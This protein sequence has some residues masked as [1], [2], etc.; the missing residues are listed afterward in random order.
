MRFLRPL[1]SLLLP[2]LFAHIIGCAVAGGPA[3]T[4]LT[5]PPAGKCVIYIYRK[6]HFTL[7]QGAGARYLVMASD[8]LVTTLDIGGYYRLEVTPGA[9]HF[10]IG[11]SNVNG[12]LAAQ[13]K[14]SQNY[15]DENPVAID[16]K[17]GETYYITLVSALEQVTEEQ[18][19]KDLDGARR[20]KGSNN[21]HPDV[22]MVRLGLDGEVLGGLKEMASMQQ[23]PTRQGVR[24]PPVAAGELRGTAIYPFAAKGAASA[25]LA[26]G[27]SSVF[28]A[29]IAANP[30]TRI[31]AE[32]IIEDLARQQGLEQSCGT[33][34]CQ[35]D[36]AEQAH[37]DLLVRGELAQVDQTF[38]L[39]VM[40][41]DLRS[42]R[43]VFSDRILS[44]R[45]ALVENASRL[46]AKTRSQA[47]SCER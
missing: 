18:G 39:S 35:I 37:A 19:K 32:D 16:A 4:G 22:P 33:E 6:A 46:G 12:G 29:E 36:L 1:S 8:Q 40:V 5:P 38:I 28:S 10:W 27:L 15:L 25:A 9:Y 42:R 13:L 23:A 44:E 21:I 20:Q 47:L 31:V 30:C 3:F 14:W 34:S 2:I 11:N 41:I 17:A 24:L 7:I 45:D 43:T 26:E